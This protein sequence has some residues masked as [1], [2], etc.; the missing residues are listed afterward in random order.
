MRCFGG[1]L[2]TTQSLKTGGDG[3]V[4]RNATTLNKMW[5][6]VITGLWT[7][8]RYRLFGKNI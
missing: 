4:K 2:R 1:I 3:K 5:K 7:K 8:Q 6:H